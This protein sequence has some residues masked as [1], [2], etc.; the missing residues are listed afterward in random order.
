MGGS[1]SSEEKK[2]VDS[3]GTVNNNVVISDPVEF[4]NKEIVCI[5]WIILAL[6][7]MELILFFYREHRRGLKKK[8]VTPKQ[9]AV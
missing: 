6:K 2:T 4:Y 5:L 7:I 9:P 3:S 1:G 8:Y